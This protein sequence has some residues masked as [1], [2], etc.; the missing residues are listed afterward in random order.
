MTGAGL[1]V[2]AGGGGSGVVGRSESRSRP[3]GGAS[4]SISA[5]GGGEGRGGGGVFFFGAIAGAGSE[6]GSFWRGACISSITRAR[7]IARGVGFGTA[8]FFTFTAATAFF[9]GTSDTRTASL[10]E[11]AGFGGIGVRGGCSASVS[12]VACGFTTGAVQACS[13]IVSSKSASARSGNA[14]AEGGTNCRVS[15]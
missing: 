10:G 4:A 6:R 8:F 2:T 5:G 7:G 14:K 13:S 15:S 11:R 9:D 1:A 12:P 3:A